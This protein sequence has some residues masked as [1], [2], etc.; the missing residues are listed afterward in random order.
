[1]LHIADIKPMVQGTFDVLI[2]N[3]LPCTAKLLPNSM[4]HAPV[5]ITGQPVD[6]CIERNTG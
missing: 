3:G 2:W 6:S 1:M 5:G 4:F